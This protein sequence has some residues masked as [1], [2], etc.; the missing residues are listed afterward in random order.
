MQHQLGDSS[1]KMI[2]C[3]PSILEVALSSTSKL[4]WSRKQQ[5]DNIVLAA[6]R[7]ECGPA[8]DVFMSFEDL[9]T[10]NK[11]LE[12][13][14]IDS[15]KTTVAYLGYSSGT[16]GK[17]KGVRTSHYNMTSVLSILYP[18]D[19]TA[20]DVHMAVLPL[21]RKLTRPLLLSIVTH[22]LLLYRHLWSNKITSLAHFNGN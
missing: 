8:G 21:N 17:A 7:S 18:F 22:Q 4:G 3:H 11:L 10:D 9:M 20:E 2:F 13:V 16:S 19:I 5:R 15:P 6:L 12:P 1:A 14:K